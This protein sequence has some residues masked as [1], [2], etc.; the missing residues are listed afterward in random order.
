MS[1]LRLSAV[2]RNGVPGI[3]LVSDY[4]I[5][6]HTH[7]KEEDEMTIRPQVVLIV[8]GT[9]LLAVTATVAASYRMLAEAKEGET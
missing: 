4:P 2:K 1:C 5:W 8:L 6:R 3:G 9:T 7:D